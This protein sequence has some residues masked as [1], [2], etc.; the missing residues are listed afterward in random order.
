MRLGWMRLPVSRPLWPPII[1]SPIKEQPMAYFTPE[2]QGPKASTIRF[3]KQ[4]AHS[5]RVMRLSDGT[6]VSFCLN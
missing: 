6:T 4:L 3:I 1:H 2:N 5:Y